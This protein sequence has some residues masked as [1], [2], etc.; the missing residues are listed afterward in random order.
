MALSTLFF[1]DQKLWMPLKAY[2]TAAI[3]SLNPSMV[4][5]L[6]Q[7][8]RSEVGVLDALAMDKN[9]PGWPDQITAP[10]RCLSLYEDGV[11]SPKCAP[12]GDCQ[13][14]D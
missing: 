1:V 13:S 9:C 8:C 3:H 14:A 12:A 11:R 4:L 6:G 5:S 7:G 2:D 10:Q